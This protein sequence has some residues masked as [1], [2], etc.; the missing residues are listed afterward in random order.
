M[1]AMI[2]AAGF[3]QRFL[4]H[5]NILPK[6]AL[7]F[8]NIPILY[9][10]IYLLLSHFNAHHSR[11]D[12]L[13]LTQLVINTHHLPEIL[14]Q[15]MD[16]KKDWPFSV[17]F[18]H[19]TQILGTG[20]GLARVADEFQSER[21]FLLCNGD[22]LIFPSRKE[23]LPLMIQQHVDRNAIATLLVMKHPDLLNSLGAVWIDSKTKT[24]QGFGKRSPSGAPTSS[25]DLEP[26]HYV[27]LQV[28]SPRIFRYL[29][30]ETPSDLFRDGLQ[31]AIHSG[32]KVCVLE[33]EALWFET[34]NLKN[35]LEATL[36]AIQMVH[37]S[38]HWLLDETLNYFLNRDFSALLSNPSR[39]LF[40]SQRSQFPE[41]VPWDGFVVLGPGSCV[42]SGTHLRNVVVGPN[43]TLPV[44]DFKDELFISPT[45]WA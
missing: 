37:Q 9:Y 23:I 44:G 43:L 22:T 1:K 20:G 27:G 6:P 24:V 30:K 4:P 32:E 16:R 26:Y 21:L 12:H 19:E 8:L 25:G 34:G 38:R 3:G 10:P 17:T 39:Y 36:E 2:L 45:A 29:S 14:R 28:L 13:G 7:P 11:S 41:D 33:D 40:R 42:Q 15:L 31:N 18:S 5:T 35:Y